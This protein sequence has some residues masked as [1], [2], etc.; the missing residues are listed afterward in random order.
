ME[1]SIEFLVPISGT[2]TVRRSTHLTKS[3]VTENIA[4]SYT[5]RQSKLYPIQILERKKKNRK[6]HAT[7]PEQTC[8][9]EHCSNWS[10]STLKVSYS[11]P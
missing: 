5:L 2:Q 8:H 6:C 4:E 11:E 7:I 10:I 3:A 1:G 9:V